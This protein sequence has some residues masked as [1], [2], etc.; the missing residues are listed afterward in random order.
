MRADYWVS[1]SWQGKRLGAG[2]LLTRHHVLTASHCLRGLR[3][4]DED[5]ELSFANGKVILGRVGERSARADLALIDILEPRE[6]TIILPM[7]DRASRGDA[8]SAPYRPDTSD[9]YLS[10]NVLSG[11]MAYRCEAG[12]EIE[13]L[14]LSCSQHLGDYSGYS[15]GPV[16]RYDTAGESALLGV[17][18][19]QYPDRQAAERASDVLFAATIAEALRCFDHLGVGHLMKVMPTDD[20]APQTFVSARK[21][22]QNDPP[23]FPEG[24]HES[25]GSRSAGSL[26]GRTAGVK[27]TLDSLDQMAKSGVLPPMYVF[28]LKVRAAWRL[29]DRDWTDEA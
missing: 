1:I 25:S 3:A 5:L 28:L 27:A 4:D 12:D 15:G 19:E 24:P 9:P 22:H 29:G 8:W 6:N 21:S 10:G 16:E 11:A 2:F 26:D 14:Q 7:A 13:A 20:V 17:L 18:L 23:K